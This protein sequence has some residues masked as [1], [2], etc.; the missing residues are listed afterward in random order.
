MVNQS[1]SENATAFPEEKVSGECDYSDATFKKNANFKG[2]TFKCFANFTRAIFKGKANFTGAVFNEGANFKGVA[3]NELADFSQTQFHGEADFSETVLKKEVRFNSTKLHSAVDFSKSEFRAGVNFNR[4]EFICCGENVSFENAVF[5]SLNNNVDFSESR[6]C[7]SQP[8]IF[9]NWHIGFEVEG[10]QYNLV[11]FKQKDSESTNQEKLQINLQNINLEILLKRWDM[12][13]HAKAISESFAIFRNPSKIVSFSGC[14]FGDM[15]LPAL[16]NED[17]QNIIDREAGRIERKLYEKE[18]KKIAQGQLQVFKNYYENAK[19][20]KFQKDPRKKTI[21]IRLVLRYLDRNRVASLRK[22]ESGIINFEKTRFFNQE[23]ADFS[24][25]IYINPEKVSFD[26]T[27]FSNEETVDFNSSYFF[28]G[29]AVDFYNARFSNKNLVDFRFIIFSN[30]DRVDFGS[31]I[32]SNGENV[33]FDYTSFSN[34]EKTSFNPTTFSNGQ[35]VSFRFVSFKSQAGLILKNIYWTQN[36]LLNFQRV[37]FPETSNIKFEECLFLPGAKINFAGVRFPEKGNLLFQRCYFSTSGSVDFTAA[38]FRH[39]TFEGGPISWLEEKDKTKREPQAILRNQLGEDY[40]KLPHEVQQRI[41]CLSEVPE[42]SPVFEKDTKVLWKDLTTESAKNLTF[43]NTSF[44]KSLFDGMTLSHIQLNAPTWREWSGRK[45]LYREEELQQERKKLN[46]G[47]K[48]GTNHPILILLKDKKDAFEAWR[49]DKKIPK[50]EESEPNQDQVENKEK[51][52]PH[53]LDKLRDIRDQY[54]QLKNNLEQQGAYQ[55]S[56]HF[57]KSEQEILQIILLD[58]LQG[59]NIYS[60]DFFSNLVIFIFGGWYKWSSGYGEK[61]S[62]A[63]RSTAGLALVLTLY[64][65]ATNGFMGAELTQP[66]VNGPVF[67]K[68]LMQTLSPFSWKVIADEKIINDSNWW[69]Y[70]VFFVGQL[71]LLGIQFPMMVMTVRR[72]FKR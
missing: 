44:S 22:G 6:F 20:P 15:E 59:K 8:C 16:S 42:F 4:G 3:F 28:N 63:L 38:L 34:G 43:R 32:F 21:I 52:D 58:K 57:H 39:T 24:N 46:A 61:L 55:Q 47:Q 51:H 9:D 31:T 72:Q 12:E 19:K 65:C 45:I 54:T 69:Q 66:W 2:K 56:G 64:N 53:Y 1:K 27:C 50:L 23:R 30:G 41:E 40:D 35:D 29:E 18:H 37:E 25:I 10:K 60:K 68:T 70:V 36:G 17:I 13:A 49:L 11:R 14:R 7:E 67:F 5:L 33:T 71:L 48:Q 62:L 26:S